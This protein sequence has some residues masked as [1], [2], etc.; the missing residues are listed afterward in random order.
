MKKILWLLVIMIS[1]MTIENVS[2]QRFKGAAI[3]GVNLTQIDGDLRIGYNKIGLNIGG[4]VTTILTD[5]W[6]FST[7]LLF[8][9]QGSRRSANE[10]QPGLDVVQLN[11]LEVPVLLHFRDWKLDFN[12]GFSYNRLF[13]YEV[14]DTDG[15]N[16]TDLK[17]YR[18]NAIGLVVGVSYI[19]GDHW[20]YDA[21]WTY[22]I[23]DL[24][25]ET[26]GNR[27]IGKGLSFRVIYTF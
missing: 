21:R 20:A 23:T 11:F 25:A 14:T 3:V 18:D 2:G 22:N 4:R 6:S 7:E 27:L 8:S 10:F 5:R 15:S 17:S 9:Q 19:S 12:A 13:S 24:N 16:V 1:F 26:G